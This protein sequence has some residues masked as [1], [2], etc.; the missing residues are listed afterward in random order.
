VADAMSYLETLKLVHRDLA[1]RN[2]LLDEHLVAKVCD[3]GL[4]RVLM[5]YDVY[6]AKIGW[7]S[8]TKCRNTI[9]TGSKF[10]L[11]WTAPEAAFKH[12]FT[13]FSDVWSFGVFMYEVMTRGGQPYHGE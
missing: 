13:V 7:D 11:K 2:V 9:S 6:E 3:F 10:P 8:I 4:A 1:A 5:D 12:N